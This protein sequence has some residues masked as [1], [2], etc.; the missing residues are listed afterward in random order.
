MPSNLAKKPPQIDCNCDP[1][2]LPKRNLLRPNVS[3]LSL[4]ITTYQWGSG[5][6][7]TLQQLLHSRNHLWHHWT[8]VQSFRRQ[9]CQQVW[10]IQ[11]GHWLNGPFHSGNYRQNCKYP[12]LWRILLGWHTTCIRIMCKLCHIWNTFL[13][14]LVGRNAAVAQT[15]V[16]SHRHN[17]MLSCRRHHSFHYDSWKPR[18]GICPLCHGFFLSHMFNLSA[19]CKY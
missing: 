18:S 15:S 9:H 10:H 17:Y 12:I 11:N 13:S 3:D 6:E 14:D 16:S 2:S 5:P 19:P 4:R 8:C 1:E 7:I